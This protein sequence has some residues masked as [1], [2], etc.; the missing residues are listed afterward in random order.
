MKI[1]HPYITALAVVIMGL[2]ASCWHWLAKPLIPGGPCQG[3]RISLSRRVGIVSPAAA[4]GVAAPRAHDQEC[5]SADEGVEGRD[6]QLAGV[7]VVDGALGYEHH[8]LPVPDQV[9]VGE[10][11]GPAAGVVGEA[12]VALVLTGAFLAKFG[13]DSLEETR[14]NFNAYQEQVKRF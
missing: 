12:M 5:T 13:G 6:D 1:R 14:R 4:T 3:R 11:R 8:S 7:V 2:G 10:A 9:R